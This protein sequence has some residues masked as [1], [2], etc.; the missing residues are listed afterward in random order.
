M[1]SAPAIT[2]DCRPSG[3][4]QAALVAVALLAAAAVLVSGIVPG[5]KAAAVVA[6]AAYAGWSLRRLRA[7]RIERCAWHASGYWRVRDR[8]GEEHPA[9]L[10]HAAV[11]G[12]LIVLVLLAGPLRRVT[13]VLLPDNCDADTRRR[14]R[15][16]LAAAPTPMDRP[17]T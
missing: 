3:R 4:L 14:L 15:V 11:R 8:Q 13:L 1:K 17:A 7:C 2:L 5:L 6:I 10:L 12:P 16:R 9:T